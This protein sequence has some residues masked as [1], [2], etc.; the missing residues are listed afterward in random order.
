M[1]ELL[2]S[3]FF[4]RVGYL[5]GAALMPLSICCAGMW[6]MPDKIGTRLEDSKNSNNTNNL[7][8]TQMI[9]DWIFYL[10]LHRPILSELIKI[11]LFYSL[12]PSS[13]ILSSERHAY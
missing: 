9:F 7:N 1:A 5:C 2:Y 6:I 10:D 3:F 11:L 4:L 8:M 13:E 12:A